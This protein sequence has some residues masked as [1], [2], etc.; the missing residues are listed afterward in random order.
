M[1]KP[2]EGIALILL[3]YTVLFVI[4]C[5]LLFYLRHR[6]LISAKTDS[7]NSY[8]SSSSS[9]SQSSESTPSTHLG[10]SGGVGGPYNPPTTEF[11]PGADP[12]I[13]PTIIDGIHVN[14]GHGGSQRGYPNMI[15]GSVLP[16]GHVN[17]PRTS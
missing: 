13:G 11:G 10:V 15:P 8:K 2:N 6:C 17:L 7:E 16:G 3:V 1:V 12:N 14:V 5:W 4:V 9:T